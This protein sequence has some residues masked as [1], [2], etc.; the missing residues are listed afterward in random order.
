MKFFKFAGTGNDF[1]LLNNFQNNL[2]TLSPEDI[3][4]FC[5]RK[6][7]VGADGLLKIEKATDPSADLKM[8][9]YNADGGEVAMCGNG[10]RVSLYYAHRF[11]NLPSNLCLQTMNA[12]YHGEVEDDKVEIEMS[13]YSKP[14]I[15]VP[16]FFQEYKNADFFN[17][18]VPHICLE[19]SKSELDELD[20]YNL[21][22][23]YAHHPSFKDGSN[24]NFF[25][26][27]DDEIFIRTFERGVE[28]ETLAC[29]TGVAAVTHFTWALNKVKTP[30]KVRT[31][32]GD[33]FVRPGS[34]EN[35]A[36]VKGSVSFVFEG[37]ME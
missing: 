28:D 31:K 24:V 33:L 2:P 3:K 12:L 20:V 13:E 15:Q 10:A 17:T 35:T 21:G 30:L 34:K 4:S 6:T 19:V 22:R 36:K 5:T 25:S 9:Y 18:G 16:D 27:V 37:S 23:V 29:G 32:G 7:G 1:V 26:Q 11:L 8:V 14:K